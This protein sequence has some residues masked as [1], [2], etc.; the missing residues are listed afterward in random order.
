[1]NHLNT[2]EQHPVSTPETRRINADILLEGNPLIQVWAQYLSTNKKVKI[3]VMSGEPGINK[4]SKSGMLEFCYMIEG[5]VE[6]TEEG[7]EPRVYK[8][9]D[10]FVMED[11]YKGIW[12]T[13]ETFKKIYV[14]V[15]NEEQA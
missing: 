7:R 1:M 12:N 14:C 15:Y 5:I 10:T 3:G 11:G 8:A 13:I 9:G 6:L 4:S 2:V